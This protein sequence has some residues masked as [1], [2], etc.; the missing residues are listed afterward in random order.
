[1]E[2]LAKVKLTPGAGPRHLA[3]HPGGQLI[4]VSTE[5]DNNVT[6]ITLDREARTLTAGEPVS[7]VPEEIAGQGAGAH[8]MMHPGG[9]MLI[10]TNRNPNYVTTMRVDPVDGTLTP[11]QRMESPVAVPRGA[12]LSPD[13]GSLI[14]AGQD[15]NDLVS[16]RVNSTTG[17]MEPLGE[18]VTVPQPIALAFV[19]QQ[20]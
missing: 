8:I 12:A 1:L 18:P 13:G 11:L 5:L 7:I 15:S 14:L 16:L 17:E 3:F 2:L 4:F 9:E 10:V 19:P 20:P 6:P